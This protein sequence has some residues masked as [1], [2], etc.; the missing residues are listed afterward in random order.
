MTQLKSLIKREFKS[1]LK[2]IRNPIIIQLDP[3]GY[4]R[5]KEKGGRQWY[6]ISLETLYCLLVKDSIRRDK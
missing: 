1:S 3:N 4:L 6:S 2:S 5:L